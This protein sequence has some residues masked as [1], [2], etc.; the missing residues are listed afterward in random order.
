MT[1]AGWT[2]FSADGSLAE[3]HDL[4]IEPRD[5]R[6]GLLD[7]IEQALAEH[8]QIL[9]LFTLLVVT[10]TQLRRSGINPFLR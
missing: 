3:P 4:A 1:R 6:H 9:P 7:L 2:I 5:L 10:H 8:S